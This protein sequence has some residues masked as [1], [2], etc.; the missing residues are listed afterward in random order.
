MRVRKSPISIWKCPNN[1]GIR[2]TE[3]AVHKTNHF[4]FTG[5]VRISH[6]GQ[7]KKKK[8][9]KK[10][11]FNMHVEFGAIIGNGYLSGFSR[12]QPGCSLLSAIRLHV[13]MWFCACLDV[14][15][16]ERFSIEDMKMVLWCTY[17]YRRFIWVC[18]E[19]VYG[20]WVYCGVNWRTLESTQDWITHSRLRCVRPTASLSL[21]GS[22]KKQW[23]WVGLLLGWD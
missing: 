2:L 7:Q 3:R 22:S 16:M 4:N 10:K 11:A 18:W 5:N 9:K 12:V 19:V 14:D 1:K 13:K 21:E 23:W 17:E 6:E 20:N 15:W 8:K